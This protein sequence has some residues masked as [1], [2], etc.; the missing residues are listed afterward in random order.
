MSFSIDHAVFIAQ[1][2]SWWAFLNPNGITAAVINL[3]SGVAIVLI[4][5][6][7]WNEKDEEPF[8]ISDEDSPAPATTYRGY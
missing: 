6:N 4:V 7:M 8:D 5:I 3:S 1:L 2:A